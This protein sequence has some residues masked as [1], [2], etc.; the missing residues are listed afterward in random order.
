[1]MG[2]FIKNSENL[3][4][5]YVRR[6]LVN[7][8]NE[9]SQDFQIVIYSNSNDEQKV[10]FIVQSLRKRKV[11]IDGAYK[12]INNKSIYDNYD[13]IFAD[14]QINDIIKQSAI[15][16]PYYSEHGDQVIHSYQDYGEL[17]TMF[18]NICIREDFTQFDKIPLQ[19][20]VPHIKSQRGVSFM[21]ISRFI[22]RMLVDYQ[23]N[24]KAGV[25]E[26]FDALKYQRKRKSKEYYIC[27]TQKLG[28]EYMIS[29]QILLYQK[30]DMS[31]IESY[32]SYKDQYQLQQQQQKQQTTIEQ[33]PSSIQNQYNKVLRELRSNNEYMR[34]IRLQHIVQ[35]YRRMS[36]ANRDIRRDLIRQQ[37]GTAESIGKV[38]RNIETDQQN[39]YDQIVAK[40]QSEVNHKFIVMRQPRKK[41]QG[42][43]TLEKLDQMIS[44]CQNLNIIDWLSKRPK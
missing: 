1:M 27:E 4:E 36:K 23:V 26:A 28:F 30:L 40:I 38:M 16:C 17:H 31:K 9:L 42:Q 35:Y 6:D 43:N 32:I 20:L 13:Q 19:I 22:T 5:L 37:Q 3:T 44:K 39:D 14:F 11:H 12:A 41:Y 2:E 7:G 33:L 10:K 34:Q 18:N 29:H 15:V 25:I 24:K 8:L 21:E